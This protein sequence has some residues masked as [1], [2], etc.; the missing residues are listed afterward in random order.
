MSSCSVADWTARAARHS[1]R[2]STP[3]D[4]FLLRRSHGLSHPVEDFLFT[5]YPF[6]PNKLK[7]WLPALGELWE[8]DAPSLLAYP[9]LQAK[10]CQHSPH[11]VTLC[12]ELM[13]AATIRIA[14]F[15]AQLCSGMEE[16]PPR[17]RCYGMHE[18][19]M[20]YRQSADQVRHQ[21]YE[22]RLSPDELARFVE[23][24]PIVCS[25]YDAFRFFS[26][27]ARPLNTLQPSL[28]TRLQQEQAA[29]L[30]ANMDVYKWCYKLWPWCGSELLGE[31]FALAGKGRHMDM[32]AS[33]YA[34]EHLGYVPIR[35]ETPEGR[36]EYEAEQRVLAEAARPLR[37]RLLSAAQQVLH[38]A[39]TQSL[40][41]S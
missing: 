22:L 20:V 5:Y 41:V 16:R 34:L 40:T 8:T 37:Q 25:H 24:Q 12:P 28:E 35:I 1:E 13:P 6:S 11:G 14:Q 4:A 3:A 29:C 7:K 38:S 26:P 31:A 32:R 36:E 19:A 21:G 30:H 17:F 33:P 10:E 27:E 18:W 23:Q 39:S 9:E 15:I 2:V